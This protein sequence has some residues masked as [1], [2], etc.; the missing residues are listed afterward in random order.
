M[1]AWKDPG[2]DSSYA[3]IYIPIGETISVN[4]AA[5]SGRE[6]TAWWFNSKDGA[7]TQIGSMT[8]KSFMDFTPPALGDENDW[9]LVMDDTRKH[10]APPG[11]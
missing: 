1:A 6:F 4:T 11:K 7:A 10:Y 9:V 2:G 3:M 8:K 5:L